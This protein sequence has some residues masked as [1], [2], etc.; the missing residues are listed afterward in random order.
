MAT[1]LNLRL[2]NKINLKPLINFVDNRLNFKVVR[3]KFKNASVSVKL[4]T[5]TALFFLAFISFIFIVQS[6]FVGTFYSDKKIATFKKSFNELT[7][8]Y[9]KKPDNIEALAASMSSFQVKNN[10]TIVIFDGANTLQP[11]KTNDKNDTTSTVPS[12][13]VQLCIDDWKNSDQYY[14]VVYNKKSTVYESYKI[15]AGVSTIVAVSPII[16][17]NN[18]S[19]VFIAFS[20]LQPVN[21]ASSTMK[22][23]YIYFYIIAIILILLISLFYTNMISKPL[24]KLNRTASKMSQL[25]FSEKCNVTSEDEIGN[26]A[27]T[28]NFLS[29]NLSKSLND[30]KSANEKLTEDIEKE[31]KLEKMRKE[32][33]AGVSHELKTPIALINGFAEGLKDNIAEGEEKDYY[34]DV[35]MDESQKMSVLISDMMDLSQLESGNFKLEQYSFDLEDLVNSIVRKHSNTFEQK[36][37]SVK[38]EILTEDCEVFGDSFRIEQVITNLIGNAIKNTPPDNSIMIIMG[39]NKDRISLEIENEGSH[40]PDEELSNIWE[41][42]YKL[43]KSRSRSLGGTGI[44]LSIVKNILTLHGSNYGVK[45]TDKGVKFYFDMECSV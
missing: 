43:D 26:L 44:G 29:D 17:N 32:F 40:I 34:L 7:A 23:F 27:G 42:F 19:K 18:V 45:N 25:D 41:K 13:I 6:L 20:S 37:I 8:T 5:V 28:L 14:K 16:S 22:E 24:K 12:F 38:T 1:N 31:K 3:I 36:K 9:K 21:E 30:L 39:K 15:N 2:K 11:A 35:I 4:F 33:V 10:A